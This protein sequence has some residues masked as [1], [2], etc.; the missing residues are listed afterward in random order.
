[1]TRNGLI[2]FSFLNR[3]NEMCFYFINFIDSCWKYVETVFSVDGSC[4]G[5]VPERKA[6]NWGCHIK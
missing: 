5:T 1:M 4:G 6:K 3:K 2:K